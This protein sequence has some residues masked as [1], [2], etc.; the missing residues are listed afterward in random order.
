MSMVWLCGGGLFEL[1]EWSMISIVFLDWWWFGR[2]I[3]MS[4]IGIILVDWWWINRWVPDWHLIGIGSVFWW[5]I[6][7]V[8][9][10]WHWI[11][12]QFALNWHQIDTGLAQDW[13]LI[14]MTLAV[15]EWVA[16]CLWIDLRLVLYRHCIGNGLEI[17]WNRIGNWAWFENYAVLRVVCS[18]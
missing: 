17:N 7:G 8:N 15:D 18:V 10:S 6:D 2:L 5:L 11:G 13:W 3:D 1:V 12:P 16:H 4:S 9:Q 14:G